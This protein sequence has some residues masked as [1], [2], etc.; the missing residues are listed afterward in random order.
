MQNLIT[1]SVLEEKLKAYSQNLITK[2]AKINHNIDNTI[3][4][5]YKNNIG[6]NIGPNNNI[7]YISDQVEKNSNKVNC[8]ISDE[9][10]EK[11]NLVGL[12]EAESNSIAE[13]ETGKVKSNNKLDNSNIDNLENKSERNNISTIVESNTANAVTEETVYSN[14]DNINKEKL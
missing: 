13:S 5:T 4:N 8:F 3:N 11:Y 14:I 6:P 1:K 9:E 12:S 7:I 10:L 2:S